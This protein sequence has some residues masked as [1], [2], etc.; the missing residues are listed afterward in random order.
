M[1][2]LL[3]FLLAAAN[4]QDLSIQ[5]E[6]LHVD[7]NPAS[8][9]IANATARTFADGALREQGGSAKI[10]PASDPIFGNGQMIE[11]IHA[12]GNSDRILVFPKLPL[13]F[14][15]TSLLNGSASI[16]VT[17]KIRPLTF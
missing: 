13:V 10:R 7:Y 5:N 6:H 17:E 4:A 9:S 1:R 8:F 3:P 11:I 14:F 15:R 16:Q 12:S 2:I